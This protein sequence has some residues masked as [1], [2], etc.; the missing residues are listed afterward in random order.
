MCI[1][2]YIRIY[3]NNQ[4][5][6]FEDALKDAAAEI[7]ELREKV[8]VNEREK[9]VA[10]LDASKTLLSGLHA[11]AQVTEERAHSRECVRAA[12]GK[13]GR[14]R[15]RGLDARWSE[16]ENLSLC[17]SPSSSFPTYSSSSSFSSS[18]SSS[19]SFDRSIDGLCPG[20]EQAAQEEALEDLAKESGAS[21]SETKA[22]SKKATSASGSWVP[23]RK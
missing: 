9:R 20:G 6:T 2:W 18:S 14:K 11:E 16:L 8:S 10:T 23:W 4:V 21:A 22:A 12:V 5:A 19:S 7:D 15:E 1:C 13:G 3:V 17:L